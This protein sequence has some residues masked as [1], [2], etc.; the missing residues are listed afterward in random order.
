MKTKNIIRRENYLSVCRLALASIFILN[1]FSVLAQE[2]IATKLGYA[3]DAK[4]LIIHADDLGLSHSENMASIEAIENGSVNS[5][6]VMMPTPW[7]LEVVDY[8]KKN[9]STH[10]FGLHLVLTSETKNYKWGPVCSID[11]VPSLVDEFGYF[12]EGC[13]T[14]VDV[15]Q[16]EM[17][18]KA[19][20]DR[21]YSMGLV[22]T[23]L[24][25][26]MGC[27]AQSEALIEVYLK[28]GQLYNLPVFGIKNYLPDEMLKKYDVK[29]LLDTYLMI[30]PEDY[31]NGSEN[32]YINAIKNLKPGLT[33]ILIHAGYNN[34]E[35]KGI[36]IDHPDFG[37]EWR[38]KDFD[39][40][41]S[42]TCKKL[43]IEENIKLVTWRQIKDALYSN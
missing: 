5:A 41:T 21:A 14:T 27:L 6:S 2:N 8:A 29:V 18:L 9:P 43:L 32:Y 10:D 34:D 38:Q 26:H 35:M 12:H 37:S 7:V 42:D 15:D 13:A 22:P 39:F 36:W 4:L 11:K 33:T 31:A 30:N 40:F 17:E 20:I 1:V 19:Q 3:A 28:M 23:H 24:D 25:T 16:V